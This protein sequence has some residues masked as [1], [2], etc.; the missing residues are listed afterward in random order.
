MTAILRKPLSA[1][2]V[3]VIL[4]FALL[5]VQ[6]R[7]QSGRSLFRSWSLFVFTPVA[8]TVHSLTGGAAQ[9]LERYVLLYGA[10]HENRKLRE[11]NSQ[12]RLELTQLRN[13][14]QLSLRVAGYELVRERA[15]F[16]TLPA[17]IIWK[18]PP[19]HSQSLF[20]N[21]GSR[22][23]V[24]KDSAVIVPRGV[25]G[26]VIALTPFTAEVELI[27]NPGAAAGGMLAE[28]RLEGIIRG[29]G[30][31]LLNWNYIPSYENADVGHVIYTSGTDRIY[32]KGIPLGRIVRSIKGNR[33]YREIQIEPLV[34]FMRLQEVL[35]VVAQG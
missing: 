31:S 24:L 27:T 13:L 34:D 11:E 22:H 4:N 35:V 18:S 9:V 16:S 1:L 20:I 5:S 7:N 21:A 14:E 25:V 30:G 29:S 3:L 26:R 8:W 12:L 23:G 15:A 10:A 17:S 32:P 2:L 28:S 19:F 33:I 6:I